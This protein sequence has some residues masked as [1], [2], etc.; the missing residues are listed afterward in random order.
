MEV[1]HQDAKKNVEDAV[2][3]RGSAP[4]SSLSRPAP[5]RVPGEV[6]IG[7]EKGE[8]PRR[9]PAQ[10]ALK[11]QNI[12]EKCDVGSDIETDTEKASSRSLGP[13]CFRHIA[14]KSLLSGYSECVRVSACNQKLRIYIFLPQ[15]M[16]DEHPPTQPRSRWPP[17]IASPTLAKLELIYRRLCVVV[18]FPSCL[19]KHGLTDAPLLIEYRFQVTCVAPSTLQLRLKGRPSLSSSVLQRLLAPSLPPA[20]PSDIS[21]PSRRIGSSCKASSWYVVFI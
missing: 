1:L 11:I 20:R 2:Q 16:P 17:L 13:S 18:L 5:A 8:G 10:K 15:T 21:P 12:L 14:S 4:T 6:G 9:R 3:Y 19:V 7:N